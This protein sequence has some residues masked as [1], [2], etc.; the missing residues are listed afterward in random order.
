[1]RRV[2][3]TLNMIGAKKKY[4]HVSIKWKKFN[5]MT[6]YRIFVP[7]GRTNEKQKMQQMDVKEFCCCLL[8]PSS[9]KCISAY[10]FDA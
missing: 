4:A 5:R 10:I 7:L 1:M 6:R 2:P 8:L 3:A 9:A